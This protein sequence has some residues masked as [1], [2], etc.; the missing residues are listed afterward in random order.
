MAL[1]CSEFGVFFETNIK[2]LKRLVIRLLSAEKKGGDMRAHLNM[3]K[4]L[5]MMSIAGFQMTII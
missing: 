4:I 1:Q 2:N 3:F 5:G